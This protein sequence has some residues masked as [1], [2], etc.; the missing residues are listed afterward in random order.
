MTI[1]DLMSDRHR[2]SNRR[3]MFRRKKRPIMK[4]G[5]RLVLL[6]MFLAGAFLLM[7]SFVTGTSPELEQE[8]ERYLSESFERDVQFDRL[9]N[10]EIYPSLVLDFHGLDI[11]GK[12][13]GQDGFES[14][15]ID[16][17][18]AKVGFWNFLFG[19]DALQDFELRGLSLIGA[20]GQGDGQGDGP[21]DESAAKNLYIETITLDPR[22]YVSP[23]G[24]APGALIRGRYGDEF[25]AMQLRLDTQLNRRG[26]IVSYSAGNP[27]GHPFNIHLGGQARENLP[28]ESSGHLIEETGIDLAGVV[29]F[30]DEH[31]MVL[32][33]LELSMTK[34]P[35]DGPV[36]ILDGSLVRRT[37]GDDFTSHMAGSVSLGQSDIRFDLKKPRSSN[38]S[39][40]ESAENTTW[41]AHIAADEIYFNDIHGEE[42]PLALFK[43]AVSSLPF[44]ADLTLDVLDIQIQQMDIDRAEIINIICAVL[45]GMDVEKISG[46]VGE[47]DIN[48]VLCDIKPENIEPEDVKPELE[49][50]NIAKDIPA[51]NDPTD[52]PENIQE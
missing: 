32:R 24:P 21:G 8:F 43:S 30:K 41:S 5:V 4:W 11:Q 47:V 14:L 45:D 27:A 29:I 31:N 2:R 12:A 7:L 46:R 25:L 50:A 35:Q 16:Q 22:G 28:G 17:F 39:V 6:G 15:K 34:N 40:N 33:D 23:E 51:E 13:D 37:L 18:L 44:L 42:S 1:P 9:N 48:S 38:E 3:P 20:G 26:N 49:D 52:L 10:I 19:V 36:K